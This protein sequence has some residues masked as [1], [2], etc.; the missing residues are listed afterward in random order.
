MTFAFLPSIQFE[1]NLSCHMVLSSVFNRA[2]LAAFRLLECR[3]PGME[4]FAAVIAAP[5]I[6]LRSWE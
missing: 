6:Q 3:Q 2:S 5:W 1:R 4:L